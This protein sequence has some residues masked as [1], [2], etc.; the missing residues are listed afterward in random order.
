MSQNEPNVCARRN[1]C[2]KWAFCSEDEFLIEKSKSMQNTYRQLFLS[3][4]EKR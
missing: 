4:K 1:T 2:R 3:I